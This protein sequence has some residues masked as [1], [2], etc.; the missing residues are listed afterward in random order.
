MIEL[1][2][3]T[4]GFS[5]PEVH[6]SAVLR[7]DFQRTLRIPDDNET[8]YLPPGLGRF[9][10]YHVDDYAGRVPE[11]WI[12]HGGVMFPMYQAEAMWIKFQSKTDRERGVEYPFVVKVAT[13]KINAVSASGVAE[14]G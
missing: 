11:E 8:Y 7:I 10:L 2:E 12:E 9:P 14:A 4:L 5:F 6:E 3:N 1:N 13:G